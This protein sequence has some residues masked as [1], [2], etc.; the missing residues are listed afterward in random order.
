ME[1][2]VTEIGRLLLIEKYV[3]RSRYYEPGLEYTAVTP[4]RDIGT[5]KYA[6]LEWEYKANPLNPLTWRILTTP[7]VYVEYITIESMEHRT[8]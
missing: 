7:R 4:G 1:V 5:P 2:N 3:L 6:Y 8:K